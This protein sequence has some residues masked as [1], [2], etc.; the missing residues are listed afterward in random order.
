MPE[1]VEEVV[2]YKVYYKCDGRYHSVCQNTDIAYELGHVYQDQ[3]GVYTISKGDASYGTGY[4]VYENIDDAIAGMREAYTQQAQRGYMTS[5]AFY[6]DYNYVIVKVRLKQFTAYG[7]QYENV[8][9]F[10]GREVELLEEI[11]AK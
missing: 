6:R 7:E 4:H 10:V 8:R 11:S 2:G 5:V 9:I 3:R 1:G